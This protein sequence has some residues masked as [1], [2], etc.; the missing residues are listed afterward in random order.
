MAYPNKTRAIDR[1]G[2]E[3]NNYLFLS[4]TDKRTGGNIV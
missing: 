2:I 1:K 4:P 3:L